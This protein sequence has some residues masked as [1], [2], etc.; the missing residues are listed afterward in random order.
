MISSVVNM[1]MI[2]CV[3]FAH[4]VFVAKD[5]LDYPASTSHR[6]EFFCK[7]DGFMFYKIQKSI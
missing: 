3:V 7:Y 2:E 1:V 6:W 4:R 5:D